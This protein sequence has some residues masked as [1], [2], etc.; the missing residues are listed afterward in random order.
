ML[1]DKIIEVL[2]KVKN[3]IETDDTRSEEHDVLVRD[4][5]GVLSKLQKNNPS[6]DGFY[7]W[8]LEVGFHKAWVADG[9]DFTDNRTH[10]M[11]AR[12]FGHLYS[13]EIKA[14]VLSRPPDKAVAEEMGFKSVKDYLKDRKD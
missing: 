11:L 3:Q 4:I 1:T 10:D 8:I 6:Q 13:H 7:Y 12:Y 2:S 14:K 9:I 5:D